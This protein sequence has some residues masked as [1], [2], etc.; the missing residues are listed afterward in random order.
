MAMHICEGCGRD[1]KTNLCHYC[2]PKA[3]IYMG[4]GRGYKNPRQMREPSPLLDADQ[5]EEYPSA[6]EHY[7]GGSIRDD[8]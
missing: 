8:I 7:H 3:A 2:T 4:N 5:V 6:I 1:S